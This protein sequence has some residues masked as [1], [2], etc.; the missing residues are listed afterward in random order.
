MA[1]DDV[2]MA[3]VHAT[4]LRNLGV[5]L[6]LRRQAYRQA[7][8]A[9]G[10]CI[11]G[12]VNRSWRCAWKAGAAAMSWSV[13]DEAYW[14]DYRKTIKLTV[15]D[16]MAN[17]EAVEGGHY[18]G[19]HV[20]FRAADWASYYKCEESDEVT[21]VLLL[22]RAIVNGDKTLLCCTCSH[23]ALDKCPFSSYSSVQKRY[24]NLTS[25]MGATRDISINKS[26]R[27]TVHTGKTA[28]THPD[29]YPLACRSV[30]GCILYVMGKMLVDAFDSVAVDEIVV[31][32]ARRL[33][34]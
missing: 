12:L 5:K 18:E 17:I 8:E 4:W 19:F 15:K 9:G 28:I 16:R 20:R 34:C 2:D 32:A 27:D 22:S 21:P 29:L 6:W 23:G 30:D 25:D 24:P 7:G 31:A 26:G 11:Y 1:A 14:V 13:V 3:A 10:L 33:R